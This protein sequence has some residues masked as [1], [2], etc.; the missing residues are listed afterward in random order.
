MIRWIPSTQ[1]SELWLNP[2]L[3]S[4]HFD[5]NR[6]FNSVNYGLGIEYKI[7][8]VTAFTIGSYRNSYY[9]QSSYVGAYWQPVA[10][11]PLHAGVVAG[12][13][14]GYS[15]TN[16]GGWFPAVLPAISLEGDFVGFNLLII[17]TIPNRISG[18]LSLQMKI[19][20]FE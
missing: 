18:S 10:L 6:N 4:Y 3:V 12:A 19:K 11:G 1:K 5:R 9:Q 15:N 14:N 7:S 2:G 13:F 16:N 8:T 20:V 17:P